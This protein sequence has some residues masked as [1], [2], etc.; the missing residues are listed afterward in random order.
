MET[1]HESLRRNPLTPVRSN[2]KPLRWFVC[3]IILAL[4]AC[5]GPAPVLDTTDDARAEASLQAMTANMSDAEKKRFQED[6]ELA[7]MPDQFSDSK[8]ADEGQPEHRLKSLNG[9]TVDQIREKASV[10]RV[11]LSH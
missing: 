10:V 5:G 9:L 8:P 3:L 6:C 4:P 7:V 1:P 11:K 2:L